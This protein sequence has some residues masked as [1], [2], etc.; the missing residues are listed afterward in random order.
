M[1]RSAS[2]SDPSRRVGGLAIAV[3]AVLLA[4]ACNSPATMP[5]AS[6]TPAFAPDAT[7]Q[8]LMLSMV[9]PAADRIWEAVATIETLD[10]TEER[11][12]RTD[13][14]WASLHIDAIRLVESTNLL[15]MSGRKVASTGTKSEN[16]G[17]EL[18]PAEIQAL[19]DEDPESWKDHTLDLYDAAKV[20]LDAINERDADKLFDNGGPLD[21]ACEHCHR[22]YWYPES[23][24]PPD[25]GSQRDAVAAP[26]AGDSAERADAGAIAGHVRLAGKPPGNRV[27]RMGMDPKCSEIYAGT[28]AVEEIVAAD[29]EG[30]LANV[31]VQLEGDFPPAIAP[32]APVVVD[33]QKCFFVPRVVGAV[34]GQSLEFHNSDPLAHNVHGLSTTTN[35]FNFA[36]PKP[37][38]VTPVVLAAE[39]GMLHIKCDMHRWM[40]VYVG[41][42]EHPYFAVSDRS[43]A[44]T[45]ERVPAGAYTIQ[46]WHERFGVLTANVTVESGR[47][48]SVDFEYPGGAAAS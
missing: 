23:I 38:M 22:Q 43:G 19:I 39:N 6:Q 2:K 3:G 16:P 5:D 1:S 45:I 21:E 7:I 34:V 24:Q 26:V 48:A 8:D 9:D 20:M 46:A 14:D 37:G 35:R 30:N 28:R 27:V 12:P 40:N 18:E 42:V 15:L 47:T 41:V 29:A 33:Q 10:G 17:I 44:F 4:G 25:A 11:R 32:S 36:Q 31:F 13:E